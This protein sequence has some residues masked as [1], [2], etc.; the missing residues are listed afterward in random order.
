MS[1]ENPLFRQATQPLLSPRNVYERFGWTQNPF[2]HKP[3][4]IA[5]SDDPRLNGTT[6]REDIR[7]NEQKE[8]ERLFIGRDRPFS[9]GFLMDYATRRGRGIGKSAFLTHQRRRIM[10]DLGNRVTNGTRVIFA[11]Y[12]APPGEG[13]CRKF[14]QFSRRLA[15]AFS[16]QRITAQAVWRLRAF[17]GL[18]P[19]TVL[20]AVGEHP[21]ET[22][23][24]DKW[25]ERHNVNI[26]DLNET[27][28]RQLR[29]LGVGEDVAKSLAYGGSP[30]LQQAESEWRQ[31]GGE[32]VF[33][34]FVHLFRA[35]GF[36]QGVLLVD[37][38]ELL[39]L[40]QNL[41]ERSSWAEDVRHY[42]VDGP[43]ESSRSGFYSL[44]LTIHPYVQEL[45]VP[46][47][48]RAGLDRFCPIGGK[49]AN[50]YTVYFHPLPDKAAVPLVLEYL[51][52][53]RINPAERGDL[54]PFDQPSLAEGLKLARGL[55]GELLQL[56]YNVVETAVRENWN[57]VGAEQIRQ[58][59]E[60]QP[61]DESDEP[62][63]GSPLE[64]A[65]VN[66]LE[67]EGDE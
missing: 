46:H 2:P 12:V 47:W 17:T 6:Y 10:T 24:D 65:H 7:A 55:P 36:N 23:G 1:I 13:R 32:L 57:Q 44:F 26:F 11:A 21:E 48:V 30:G 62:E 45:L 16:E 35:A 20:A 34:D 64:P 38:L 60:R 66:L 58:V 28:F 5:E 8:F 9:V 27:V 31:R 49:M 40:H 18:I 56:L 59:H 4:V 33:D 54:R 52:K 25:L 22:I 43:H 42:F 37:N 63:E 51:E 41:R 19:E 50:E 53:S 39:V 67:A 61:P 14:W 3:G 15:E 29:R